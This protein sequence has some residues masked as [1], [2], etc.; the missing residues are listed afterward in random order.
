M[1]YTVLRSK[2]KYISNK[3]NTNLG[4]ILKGINNKA[5]ITNTFN[6]RLTVLDYQLSWC[7]NFLEL[8]VQFW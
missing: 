2:Y 5:D 8:T 4:N 7:Y 1:V 3:L 6:Q